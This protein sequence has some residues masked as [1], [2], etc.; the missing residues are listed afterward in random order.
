MLDLMIVVDGLGS[1]YLFEMLM[2]SQRQ[3]QC[4]PASFL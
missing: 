1:N 3:D 4:N 2:S